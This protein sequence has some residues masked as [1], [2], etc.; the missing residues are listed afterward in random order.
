MQFQKKLLLIG[1]SRYNFKSDDGQQISA[2]KFNTVDPDEVAKDE[3]NA[4]LYVGELKGDYALFEK[5][6]ILKPLKYYNFTLDL[7]MKG[8][9]AV[10][11]VIDVDIKGG[12]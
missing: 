6:R 10:I 11:T 5:L 9:K 2:C 7:T 12:E 3:N 4:G 1:G 8:Q